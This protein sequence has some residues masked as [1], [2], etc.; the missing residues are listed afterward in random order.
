MVET[1]SLGKYLKKEREDR[2]LT[3]KEVSKQIKVRESY[4]KAV[5]EDRHDLLPS[6]TYVKGF[7]SAYAKYLG[8]DSK[9]VLRRYEEAQREEKGSQPEVL[10]PKERMRSWRALWI[11]GAA[12]LVSLI[13]IY[14]LFSSSRRA[15]SVPEPKVE[16]GKTVSEVTPEGVEKP[17]VLEKKGITLEIKAVELTWTAIQI[18]GQPVREAMFRTGDAASYR[19]SERIEIV[20]GNAGGVEMTFNERRLEKIGNS[21]EVVTVVFTPEGIERIHRGLRKP[22]RE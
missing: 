18:D 9:E 4:L 19:A 14:L 12:V 3:L 21:G 1:E 17:A 20:I 6:A 22:T 13:A 5:E 15:V 10:P 8:L 7:L 16:A 11:A 2:N